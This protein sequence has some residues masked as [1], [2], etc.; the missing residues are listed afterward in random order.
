MIW[1]G[2]TICAAALL[3]AGCQLLAPRSA[4]PTGDDPALQAQWQAHRQQL[5]AIQG[6]TLQGRAASGGSL[7]VKA[8]L[9]WTQQADGHFDLR[10]A[11]PFGAGGV[12]INGTAQAVEIRT[13]EGS[14]HTHDP[15][16]WMQ[17]HLGWTF[18]IH[19][20][21]HWILGLPA[22]DSP[23]TQML[24]AEGRLSRLLQDGWQLNY[25]DYVHREGVS[26]PRR[27]DASNGDVSLKLVI[28]RWDALVTAVP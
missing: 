8:D 17:T 11:G 20:L 10:L 2:A 13:R 6:F 4:E 14:L 22:P 18:P 9:R 27:L 12:Q 7:G 15:E 25:T 23:H 19:G 3:L 16:A 26:L 1:R 5:A 21:R 24:G 28:D